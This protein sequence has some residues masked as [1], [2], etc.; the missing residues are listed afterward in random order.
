ECPTKDSGPPEKPPPPPPKATTAAMS[1]STTAAPSIATSPAKAPSAAP[2][3]SS[4]SSSTVAAAGTNKI[5][6][7]KMT[8][9]LNET[10]K[11]L[12]AFQAQS[13][14]ES[15]GPTPPAD[16]LAMI[17]QQ[18]DEVRRLKAIT[19]KDAG[20]PLISSGVAFNSAVDWYEAR[21]SSTTVAIQASGSEEEEALLD[22]GASHAYRAAGQE[23]SDGNTR[24]VAVT[25]PTGV[26]D[27]FTAF[28]CSSSTW[29]IA[30]QE[31]KKT[32]ADLQLQVKAIRD[33][34]KAG[35]S[36]D[37]HLQSL[38]EDGDR[39]SM[40]G[41]LH[42]SP[43]FAAL[44]PEVLLGLP[45]SV[46]REAKDGWKLL[47]GMPWSRAKR[48]SLFQS[49][50]WIVHLCSG[51]ERTREAKQQE[52][53]RRAFWS[54]SLNG[55][56]G[57]VDVDI[58]ASKDMDLLR[59]DAVFKVLA[60]AALAGKV[61]AI[62]GGPPRHAFP[63]DAAAQATSPQQIKELKIV[64]CM[65][66]LWYMAEVGRLKAWREGSLSGSPVKPHVGFMLEHPTSEEGKVSL[67]DHPM[68]KS[69]AQED[70]MGEV[71]CVLNDRLEILLVRC[72]LW[73]LLLMWRRLFNLGRAYETEKAFWNGNYIYN[74][75]IFLTEGI[76]GAGGYK[77]LMVGCYRFPKL[78]GV[79]AVKGVDDVKSLGP[80]P[81][82]GRD[83]I[84]D[85]EE[86][87][88]VEKEEGRSSSGTR[89]LCAASF[90]WISGVQVA[91]DRARELQT[92]A[93]ESWAA[94]RDIEVTR[95]Q[96]SDPA[97]NGTAERAVGAIKA[98][99]R[100]LLGQ[101]KELSG[102]EDDAV[103]TW[104]PFA[105]ETAVAQHQAVAFGRKLPAVA[106][107]GSKVFTKRKGYGQGGRFDLQPRWMSAT[108][109]GPARSVPG[110]HL[111][112]TDEGIRRKSS[113]VELAGAVGLMPGL[114]DG[115][116]D[117]AEG[118]HALRAI[119]ALAGDQVCSSSDEVLSDDAAL[120]A[121]E[122]SSEESMKSSGPGP[123]GDLAAE[124]LSEGRFSMNDCLEVLQN[125]NL[126]RTKK[127]RAS[128]WK[129][130]APP[131]IHTTLGAYQ[132]G[133]WS[134][135]TTA[136]TR[137]NS[138]PSH[139][140]AMF[141]HHCGADVSF[142]SM[143]VARDLC[144]DAHK[145]RFNLKTSKNYVLTVG[146]FVGGGIWQEGQREGGS[147]KLHKTMSWDG[148]P[149]WTV[150]AHTVGQKVSVLEE[151]GE[152]MW[153]RRLLDEEENLLS[154]IPHE[155]AEIDALRIMLVHTAA[156]G[157][158]VA[159]T[160]IRNAFILA[161][162]KEEDED[163]DASYALY[164]PKVFQLAKVEYALRLWRVDRALYGFRRP[165]RLWGKFRDRRL[166]AAK[167]F[168]NDGYIYLR[169]HRADENIWSAVVV[170]ADG[171]E[172]TQAYV[173]VYVDD[174]LYVGLQSVIVAIHS[175][176]TEEWKASPLT[177]AS[178]TSP[179]RNGFLGENE[180]S[181]EQYDEPQL[182]R[183]QALTGELLWLSGKSRPDL[184]HTVATM[185]SW[186]L[187][188]PALVEKIGLRALGYLKETID[189]E[190]YYRPRRLDHY[191]EGFSDASFAPHG[192]RSV[193]CCLT[194]YLEQPV[195]WRCGRQALVALSG[196]EAELIEAI[197]AAQM[198]YGVIAVT[199]EL[200]SAKPT[201]VLKVD[202]SAAVG[203]SSESAGTWK[204]RHLRVRA[205]HLRE[206][207][208]LK[209]ITT[210]H[211]PGVGQ[212]GDLGT[213]AFHRPRLQE[214]LRLWGLQ[215]PEARGE[216]ERSSSSGSMA[217][218]NGTVAVLARLA[219]VLGWLIQVSRAS[220]VE[221]GG[222]LQ[223]SFPWEDWLWW[224][225]LQLSAFG[226][227]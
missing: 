207:V 105:A 39:T 86:A 139:L 72:G 209:E 202:N 122:L 131:P 199:N 58:T 187:K 144:T 18:L 20:A 190:L 189:V 94:A 145:D 134:G 213:K 23:D 60:W 135:V 132:K 49:D 103:R 6:A 97:G 146:N 42:T 210:E 75:I 31:F 117:G 70:L 52:I 215:A 87:H 172:E 59:Q 51:D 163:D 11:M 188:C 173:N 115:Q 36:Y 43:V 203:L 204:T 62:I 147:P 191:V 12:K 100:V 101:A 65:L 91:R 83:W 124:Y 45:E 113:I 160:D 106:R 26:M 138:L 28:G 46:P 168:Y 211:I 74:E 114:W 133:P 200:Q 53:M 156:Y 66:M 88:E 148:G 16:P 8:E 22:S 183:A 141:Q 194:R 76:D 7:A 78:E 130:N 13:G 129:D 108:Y 32:V 67:F 96:G 25:L 217:K 226:R 178:T 158:L 63:V 159:S 98:R 179:L 201:L 41:F 73:S 185:S 167:I 68:W 170:A 154:M 56:D 119:L 80:V 40:A 19:V 223:V 4:S 77:Y 21:L 37:K 218:F 15:S 220:P 57:I 227:L 85:E 184:L 3:D 157:W 90:Q 152:M 176:L 182:R 82:D 151:H 205:Y 174:I 162:I 186:C 10:N 171:K 166:R 221:V 61:K 50:G 69:F 1:A 198:S 216:P 64:A 136:T 33:Q 169:Q 197:S 196:A 206:A 99:I 121:L 127:Q 120:K 165:P 195:A 24:M 153:T 44:P 219:V 143:T 118:A 161:P 84:L 225:W 55:G 48:R 180:A 81:D 102:A 177:W 9:I 224:L 126:R 14:P 110:G 193:G 30:G 71:P 116:E 27:P 155:E 38:Q 208:R 140:M 79:T 212:L 149:K 137:H 54:N 142:T 175:W 35:W 192:S 93:L 107:F 104:W 150:I 95:T 125:E 2:E 222:G 89:A 34:G 92:D 112:L 109:L 128:A 29:T 123:R 17:Q 111:V 214:L 5:D 47:K 164:P 181:E